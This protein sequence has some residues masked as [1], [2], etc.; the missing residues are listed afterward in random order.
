MVEAVV[1]RVC[2][3]VHDSGA[4]SRRFA[5]VRQLRHRYQSRPHSRSLAGN[6]VMREICTEGL[7]QTEYWR[8]CSNH[9]N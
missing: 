6:H 5:S 1:F 2:A 4:P 7:P 3:D 8:R 9:A